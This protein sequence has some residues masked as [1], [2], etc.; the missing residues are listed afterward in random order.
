M[1][2]KRG[3]LLRTAGQMNAG[4]AVCGA[5]FL[6]YLALSV[7]GWETAADIAAVVFGIAALYVFCS[8]A[9]E[10]ARDRQAV[11]CSLLWGTGALALLLGGCGVLT[12]KLWLGV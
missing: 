6:L 10:W 11:S 1:K 2:E 3:F 9:A 4:A 12:V 7:L 5:G 8:V